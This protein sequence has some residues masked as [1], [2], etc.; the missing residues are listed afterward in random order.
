MFNALYYQPECKIQQLYIMSGCSVGLFKDTVSTVD[1]SFFIYL[2]I[3][4]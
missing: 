3:Y 1:I 2:L 4:L